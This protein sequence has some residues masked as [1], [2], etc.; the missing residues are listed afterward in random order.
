[1]DSPVKSEDLHKPV[2]LWPCHNQGGNQVR[3]CLSVERAEFFYFYNVLEVLA[4]IRFLLRTLS[5]MCDTY[6][7]TVQYVKS[8][9][10]LSLYVFQDSDMFY[11]PQ[12]W[13]LSKE[14]EIRRDEACLDYA[15]SDVILYPCHGSKGNQFWKYDHQVGYV[16]VRRDKGQ[17]CRPCPSSLPCSLGP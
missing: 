10:S 15:G 12:Y 5:L 14:G 13:M 17:R 1:M 16:Y 2:G 3:V 6:T 7:R 11:L 4:N 9:E 8:D